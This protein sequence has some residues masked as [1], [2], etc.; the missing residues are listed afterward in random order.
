MSELSG[1]INC[2]FAVLPSGDE[3]NSWWL[4]FSPADGAID[5][6]SADSKNSCII[7]RLARSSE[8]FA[9][10]IIS[11]R[12][13]TLGSGCCGHKPNSALSRGSIL[14]SAE[15]LLAIVIPYSDSCFLCDCWVA[16][17]AATIAEPEGK[18][19]WVGRIGAQCKN[20]PVS[21]KRCI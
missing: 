18:I 2:I 1:R 21:P 17:Q 7:S 9:C 10:S 11:S 16:K 6:V 14:G 15:I 3:V 8:E 4:I 20:S 19:H 12:L 13:E 5:S